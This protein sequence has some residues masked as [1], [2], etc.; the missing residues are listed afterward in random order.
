M[1]LRL[2]GMVIIAWVFLAMTGCIKVNRITPGEGFSLSSKEIEEYEK[3]VNRFHDGEAAI[4]LAMH[5]LIWEGDGESFSRWIYTAECLGHA[6]AMQ[7]P[8]NEGEFMVLEIDGIPTKVPEY[9]Y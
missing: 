4:I 3:R 2:K 5:Y 8:R 6:E 1:R 7:W 9:R